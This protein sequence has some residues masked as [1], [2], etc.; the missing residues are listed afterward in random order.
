MKHQL[1][2]RERAEKSS[3]SV[4]QNGGSKRQATGQSYSDMT[5]RVKVGII[6]K[7]FPTA[8]LTTAQLDVL[9]DALLLKVEQQR[10][11]PLKPKFCNLI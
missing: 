7:D 4:P 9:Q 5:K 11:E 1:D 3:S 10:D 2:P 6:P 8:Q